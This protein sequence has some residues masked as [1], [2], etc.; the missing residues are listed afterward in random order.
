MATSPLSLPLRRTAA[1]AWFEKHLPELSSRCNSFFRQKQASERDEAVADVLA[2]VFEY[3]INAEPRG[4]LHRLTPFTLVSFFARAFCEGRRMIGASSLDVLSEAGRRR[5]GLRVVS[6]EDLPDLPTAHSRSPHRF[7][8]M[9]S[10]SKGDRPLENV[11]RDVDYVEILDRAGASAKVR[12]V[13]H[14]LCETVGEGRQVE[15]ARELG[16]SPVRITQLKAE[17]AGHL[18]AAGYLPAGMV[19]W[20]KPGPNT[21]RRSR[22]KTKRRLNSI[23]LNAGTSLSRGC[24]VNCTSPRAAL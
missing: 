9:L 13:F 24:E 8:E 7:A 12:R 6:L 11:R 14:F 3:A 15:L 5:H 1:H 4:K 17:L 21:R 16:V 2:R 23:P 20:E 18:A 19:H 10:D 22:S